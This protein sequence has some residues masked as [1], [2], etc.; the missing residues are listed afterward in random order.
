MSHRRP[1]LVGYDVLVPV[2]DADPATVYLMHL[3]DGQPMALRGTAAL[4]WVLANDGEDDVAAAL[5]SLLDTP[6]PDIADDVDAY[7]D[8]LVD[9][10]WL[11]ERA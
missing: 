11:E 5:A 8:V 3:P 6:R 10:G 4:I 7:L 2:S 9:Q 1:P